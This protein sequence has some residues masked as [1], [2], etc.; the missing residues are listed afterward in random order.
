MVLDEASLLSMLQRAKDADVYGGRAFIV[1]DVAKGE[2]D[3]QHILK[4]VHIHYTYRSHTHTFTTTRLHY[5]YIIDCCVHVLTSLASSP[6]D[7]YLNDEHC[8]TSL[9]SSPRDIYLNYEH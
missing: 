1:L 9:V 7:I 6:G 3:M 4:H 8:L 2:H 5:R